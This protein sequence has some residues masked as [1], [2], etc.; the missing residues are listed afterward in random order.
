[1]R[2]GLVKHGRKVP[3][4][5][6]AQMHAFAAAGSHEAMVRVL[7][8]CGLRLGELLLLSCPRSA[9]TFLFEIPALDGR[10]R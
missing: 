6:F 7:S 10:G 9:E 3:V 8:D 5:S 4:Y 1:V 2:V